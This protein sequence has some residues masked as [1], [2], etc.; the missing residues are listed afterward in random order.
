MD[1]NLLKKIIEYEVKYTEHTTAKDKWILLNDVI[2]SLDVVTNPLIADVG[3]GGVTA[4]IIKYWFPKSS[5]FTLNQS[6]N[7]TLIDMGEK[8][9][10]LITLNLDAN[11]IDE[12]EDNKLDVIFFMDIIEHLIDPDKTLVNLKR[13]LKKGG[14]LIISTPNFADIYNR[15]FMLFGWST[16]NYNVSE[17]YKTGNPF[18]KDISGKRHGNHK[19]VFMVNQLVELL[20]EVYGLEIV[21]SKGY[22]YYEQD[23]LSYYS[24][25]G[26]TEFTKNRMNRLELIRKWLSTILPLSLDEGMLL[27]C[28]KNT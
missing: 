6:H 17:W 26:A 25:K 24:E 7:Q 13:V 19:S 15:I 14:Y 20:S 16:H 2:K 5:L 18:I 28:R 27:I 4:E 8:F 11:D 10:T 3:G 21:Y 22:S 9:S 1:K 23:W 12:F